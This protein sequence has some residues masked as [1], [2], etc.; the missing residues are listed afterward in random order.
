[1]YPAGG[2]TRVLNC[3]VHITTDNRNEGRETEECEKTAGKK[4]LGGRCKAFGFKC[5]GNGKL[6]KDYL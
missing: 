2:R 5:K 6:I 4:G 1:M 3:F